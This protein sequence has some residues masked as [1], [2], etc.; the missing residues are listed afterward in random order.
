MGHPPI[1][2]IAKGFR[3]HPSLRNEANN[4]DS[5]SQMQAKNKKKSCVAFLVFCCRTPAATRRRE[6][7]I[8]YRPA[9]STDK[10]KT[11]L[12]AM[13]RG[14]EICFETTKKRVV[15]DAPMASCSMFLF[16][17]Q[18]LLFRTRRG[19]ADTSIDKKTR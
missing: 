12:A 1:S 5:L 19:Q 6:S 4:I 3:L 11:P 9:W 10:K 13:P 7:E 8:R 18:K 14:D 16:P 2:K 17:V 15:S